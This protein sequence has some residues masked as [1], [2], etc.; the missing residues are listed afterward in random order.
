MAVMHETTPNPRMTPRADKLGGRWHVL[1][2]WQGGRCEQVQDFAN[3]AD[4]Q[5]WIDHESQAWIS[6]RN[7]TLGDLANT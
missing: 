4:A 7:K 2:E 6:A 3:E 1:T 5:S